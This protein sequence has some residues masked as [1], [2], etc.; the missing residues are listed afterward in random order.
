[1]TD[2]PG[3]PGLP[4]V[5]ALLYRADWAKVAG[6]M[7]DTA[8]QA[9]EDVKRQAGE[10]IAAARNLLGSLGNRRRP[11]LSRELRRASP[12]RRSA[13]RRYLVT[14]RVFLALADAW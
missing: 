2:E 12:S 11:R 3:V 6:S 13:G 5:I 10:T 4:A 1:M 14:V 8:A 9:A 7:A